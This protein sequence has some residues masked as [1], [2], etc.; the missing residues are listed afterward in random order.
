MKNTAGILVMS[1]CSSICHHVK[2]RESF[3][4]FLLHFLMGTFTKI[5]PHNQIS[6]KVDNNNGQF[7]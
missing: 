7:T 4:G 6:V 1:V 5:C 2:I 3:K